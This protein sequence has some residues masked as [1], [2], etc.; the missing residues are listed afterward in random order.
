[1]QMRTEKEFF[2]NIIRDNK[3][4]K[5]KDFINKTP[6]INR[7]PTEIKLGVL[8]FLSDENWQSLLLVSKDWNQLVISVACS[9]LDSVENKIKKIRPIGKLQ[10]D[11]FTEVEEYSL[12]CPKAHP[13]QVKEFMTLKSELTNLSSPLAQLFLYHK[14]TNKI[15]KDIHESLLLKN[16][17]D[18][19]PSVTKLKNIQLYYLLNSYYGETDWPNEIWF[20]S[21]MF[22][23]GFSANHPVT[24]LFSNAFLEIKKME[25][26]PLSLNTTT[27]NTQVNKLSLFSFLKAPAQKQLERTPNESQNSEFKSV[28]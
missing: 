7:V 12:K 10:E 14:K 20:K 28:L 23:S 26:S 11:L 21:A 19:L 8:S 9:Y 16:A 1:M 18:Q 25:Q 27:E 22:C 6:L 5:L 3:Q 17:N 4:I 13:L 24:K 15:Q 2:L